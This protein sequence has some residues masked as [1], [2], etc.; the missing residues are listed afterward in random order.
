MWGK[1]GK[2]GFNGKGGYDESPLERRCGCSLKWWVSPTT[3][4]FPTQN[5]HLKGV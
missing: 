4:G 5:D 3:M 1:G 2:A